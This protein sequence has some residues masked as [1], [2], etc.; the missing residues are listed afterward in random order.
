MNEPSKAIEVMTVGQERFGRWLIRN[1]ARWQVG[2][3]RLSKGRLGK[4]FRGG[5][6]GLLTF[7]GR[8]SGRSR[9][10]PLVYARDGERVFLAASQ[11]GMSTHPLW[12]RSLQEN[13]DVR[14]QIGAE[15]RAMRVR[16]AEGEAET[17]SGWSRL[18]AV[19]PD[20]DEYR[21]RA[22]LCERVIPLLVLEPASA[23]S[24]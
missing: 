6:V 19:Y 18:C 14:F 13:P 1:I 12:Y 11:G 3:Y 24:A 7:T 2:V 15:T 4:S 10:L 9:T 21:Q 17:E 23:D 20:F 8:R 5:Q 16:H 22:T